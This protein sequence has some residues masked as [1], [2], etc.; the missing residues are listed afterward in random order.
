MSQ[1]HRG[2]LVIDML[3]DFIYFLGALYVGDDAARVVSP[4]VDLVERER[5]AGSKIIYLCDR[6]NRN[7]AEFEMFP[8]HCIAGTK[9]ANIISELEPY[10]DDV[11]IYKRRFSGFAG[12]DL[13]ITLREF[14]IEELVLCGVCTNIC[15]LY[16]AADARNL[17]YKVTVLRDCVSS[18]DAE[19]H[20]FA[21]K[22]MENTLGVKVL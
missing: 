2:V 5:S 9:G 14:D 18:F 8:P 11:I 10:E 6:H 3:V 17:N 20:N 7:D 15:V 16:T 12:T 1:K 21:L 13:D 4:I 19:A 22:E